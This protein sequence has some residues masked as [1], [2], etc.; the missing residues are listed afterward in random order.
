ML[1]KLPKGISTFREIIEHDYLYIDKTSIALD[2][3]ESEKYVFLSRPRRFGKSLFIDTLHSLFEGSKKLFNGLYIADKWDWSQA[4][5]V[6]K[7]DFGGTRSKKDLLNA[8]FNILRENQE[9]LGVVCE[10]KDDYALFF[11]ELIKKASKKHNQKVVVLIDEYDKPILDNLDQELVAKEHREI[12]KRLYSQI[13]LNDK[14]IRFA[15]LTGVSKFSKVSL[16]SGLNNL[17]DIS[18]LEKYGS[19]CG[20]T[21]NDIETSFLP[22]LD[23]VDL[24]RL[25]EWYNGYYFLGEKVYNPYDILLFINSDKLYKNY[26]FESGTPTFLLELIRKSSYFL[27]DFS[28]LE[29]D[30]KV[31]NSFDIEDISLESVMLQS[32]YLTIREMVID[33][34]FISYR[35]DFPNKEV[36][37]SFNNYLS[38][39]FFAQAPKVAIKRELLEILKESDLEG[40]ERVLKRLFA[41]IA[42]NN[43]TKN[44]IERYEGFYASVIYAYFASLG[45]ELIAEDVTNRGRID[46]TLKYDGKTYLFEFKTIPT[47]SSYNIVSSK[48]PLAQIRE[49]RYYEKYR[50]DIYIIGIVFNTEERVIAQFE[51]EKV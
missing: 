37:I 17:T 1:K 29:V 39:L 21:Q 14:D 35:L 6:I 28:N 19:I 18:L 36:R 24:D 13:K 44:E 43:F 2:L 40:L 30:E 41:S 23:G 42:Y 26:W 20:Y 38:N 7:I 15:M 10:E 31:T 25:K 9:R 48:D 4:Y 22:Y 46:L 50:G 51:W 45:V 3:V 49:K 47:N 34:D 16:F 5:P 12:L 11:D 32:G 33:N 27:P 8:I